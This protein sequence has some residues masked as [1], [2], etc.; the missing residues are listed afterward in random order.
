MLITP[1]FLV[2]SGFIAYLNT[3]LVNVN[4][5]YNIHKIYCNQHLNTMYMGTSKCRK[6]PTLKCIKFPKEIY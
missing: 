3:T 5:I 4:L 1:I 2:I 6:I